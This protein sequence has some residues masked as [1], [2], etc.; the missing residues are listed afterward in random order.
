VRKSFIILFIIVNILYAKEYKNLEFKFKDSD[1]IFDELQKSEL[2]KVLQIKYPPFYKFWKSDPTFDSKKFDGYREKL[3]EH[4]NS[5]GFYSVDIKYLKDSDLSK[6]TF[7]I[8]RKNQVLVDSLIIDDEFKDIIGLKSGEG[9]STSLFKSSKSQIK[10]FLD[11]NGYPNSKV[12][13]KAYIN[14]ESNSANIEFKVEKDSK[15]YFGD[16]NIES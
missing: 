3:V 5:S 14:K 16:T 12:D 15:L 10:R 7:E 8:D 9:F 11:E 1:L 4:Y 13:A 6:V 2:L